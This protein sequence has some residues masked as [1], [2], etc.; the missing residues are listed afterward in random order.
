MLL[1]LF[2]FIVSVIIV[3][4]TLSKDKKTQTQ[5]MIFYMLSIGLFVGLGDMLG[6]YDR[7]IYGELFDSMADVTKA[8]GNPW[9]SYAYSFF[10]G[11]FGFSSLG[12]LLS[13]VTSNRY[14]YI[15]IL[16]LCIYVLLILSLTTIE[17]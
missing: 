9:K 11:E 12:A 3:F 17:T 5:W 13:Y 1:Y 2:W 10:A 4:Y 14:I 16:T 7:Y 6:G 15:L 8:G